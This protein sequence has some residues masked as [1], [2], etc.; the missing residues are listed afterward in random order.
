M[1]GGKQAVMCFFFVKGMNISAELVHMMA[2][3]AD[4]LK[5]E[6]M[7]NMS[8]IYGI[9]TV[10]SLLLAI[11]YCAFVRKKQIW[12]VWMYIAVFVVNLGY[13]ALAI[14]KTLEEALLANRIAYLG[15]VFLPLFMLMT[16]IEVC[17]FR[18]CKWF[19]AVLICISAVMFLIA[20]SPGYLTCYYDQVSLT[21]VNG[22]AKLVR[23]YGPLHDLYFIYLI[24]YLGMMIGVILLSFIKKRISSFKH[25]S[26]LVVVGLLNISIW[27]IEQFINWDFEILSVSY[28]ISELLLLFLYGMI[29]DYE[30]MQKMS[31]T[32][33]K[34][35][36]VP[37]ETANPDEDNNR[38][39]V[40]QAM[41][42]WSDIGKLTPREKDVLQY[43]L[44]DIKRKE[45][46]ETLCISES[47][48]KTHIN[49]IFQKLEVSS[50]SEL[51]SKI[52]QNQKL[53][54][55]N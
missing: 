12:L 38:F 6:K 3:G 46:A 41:D 18:Y 9:I 15:S 29:E 47:T 1:G 52:I 17:R 16:V 42:C 39:T 27:L 49:N 25:A 21:F 4:I 33:S 19:P 51:L 20:A 34:D 40:Q 31:S 54:N 11:G 45:I 32:G 43:L 48:V 44:M 24:I 50:R 35:I 55:D 36:Y 10:L 14:S 26:I 23:S 22:M 53:K 13:F 7:M 5:D 2:A 30:M 8:I 28:V 37:A